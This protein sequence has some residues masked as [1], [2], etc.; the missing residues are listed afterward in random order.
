MLPVLVTKK[1]IMILK[2][3]KH[4]LNEIIFNNKGYKLIIA[5]S[6]LI[7]VYYKFI[8]R[9]ILND[10]FFPCYIYAVVSLIF[11]IM[12]SKSFKE[13]LLRKIDF[14]QK[15]RA[16]LEHFL[17]LIYITCI[18]IYTFLYFPVSF[19]CFLSFNN[20]N[21]TETFNC[22]ITNVT[23]STRNNSIHFIFKGES[24]RVAEYSNKVAELAAS[25]DFENYQLQI[26]V[27]EG[28]LNTYWLEDW[29]IVE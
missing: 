20:E 9:Y 14:K 10:N 19:A 6:I 5:V 13:L 2:K 16:F 11:F 24:Y 25:K 17:G 29:E 27:K 23:A 26:I 4:Y 3:L 8:S 1:L 18:F 7:F 22:E 28:W 15:A 21:F 12:L